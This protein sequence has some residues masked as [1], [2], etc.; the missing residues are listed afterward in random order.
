MQSSQ[1]LPEQYH[2]VMKRYST[3]SPQQHIVHILDVSSYGKERRT[4][5]FEERAE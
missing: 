4:F 5:M 3:Q 1:D 2:Q